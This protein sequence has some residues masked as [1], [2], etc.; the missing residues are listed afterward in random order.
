MRAPPRWQPSSRCNRYGLFVSG[1]RAGAAVTAAHRSAHPSVPGVPWWGAVLIAVSATA[2]GFAFDA[3]TG[4]KELTN[5]FAA[6]YATGCVAAVLAV[7]QAGL[8]SAVVQPPVLLFVSVPGAYFLFHGAEISGLKDVLINCGYPLIERFPLMLF[9][10]AGVLLIG[11]GRAYIGSRSRGTVDTATHAEPASGRF[12]AL[13]AKVFRLLSFSSSGAASDE[14]SD[15][16]KRRHAI[17]RTSTPA[18][19][20][21]AKSARGARAAKAAARGAAGRSRHS[22]ATEVTDLIEPIADRPRRP[23]PPRAEPPPEPRRRRAPA[24]RA[25]RDPYERRDPYDRRDRYERDPYGGRRDLFERR[26]RYDRRDRY[27]RR[28]PHERREPYE[29][30]AQHDRR[31]RHEAY[32]PFEAYDE[33]NDPF[34]AY[35]P[36]QRRRP[37]S[38]GTTG[39]NGTHHPISRVR[40]RGSG[41]TDTGR[42]DPPARSRSWEADTWEYD[43]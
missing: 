5:V 10:S 24:A 12:S 20:T 6:L 40:Y 37:A 31:S 19:K 34:E 36:P 39:G 41:T 7:R 1:Q 14:A 4:T 9:T 22:R 29:R 23:R 43:I 15:T 8:F 17:D 32:D 21:P 2:I 18:R 16:G 11:L 38:N 25:S 33:A 30:R 28:D 3:G 35:P 26:D 42:S 13:S 27:E